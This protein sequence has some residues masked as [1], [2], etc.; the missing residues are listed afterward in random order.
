MSYNSYRKKIAARC[1]ECSPQELERFC[2]DVLSRMLP[3]V[4][5]EALGGLLAREVELINALLEQARSENIEFAKA[6]PVLDGLGEIAQSDEEHAVETDPVVIQFLNTMESWANLGTAIAACDI[7]D[8]MMT[9]LDY[10]Y[11]GD[12]GLD[13]W[14]KVPEIQREFSSQVSCL[15]G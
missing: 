12:I 2:Y 11:A 1:S 9:I 10:K 13:E 6:K 3:F 5:E 15:E 8:Y 7:S 4:N 14:L